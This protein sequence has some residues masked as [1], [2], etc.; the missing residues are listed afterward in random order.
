VPGRHGHHQ[1][2][3]LQER[4]CQFTRPRQRRGERQVCA[5]AA[6]VVEQLQMGALQQGEPDV[7][8]LLQKRPQQPGHPPLAERVQERQYHLAALGVGLAGGLTQP[9][10]QLRQ[11]P[12]RRRGEA[13]A[14]TAEPDGA[15]IGHHHRRAQLGGQRRQPPTRGRLRQAHGGRC[16]GQIALLGQRTQQRQL[17]GQRPNERYLGHT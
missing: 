8:V 11:R 17:R 3:L 2:L 15:P 5:P 7:R 9:G 16:P 14:S 10:G 1:L 13:G 12:A 4:P 6:N